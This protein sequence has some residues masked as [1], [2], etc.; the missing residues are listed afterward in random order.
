[1]IRGDVEWGYEPLK[2]DVNTIEKR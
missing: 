1:M 2:S